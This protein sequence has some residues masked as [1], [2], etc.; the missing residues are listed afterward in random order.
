MATIGGNVSLETF[1]G[2]IQGNINNQIATGRALG[3]FSLVP[4]VIPFQRRSNR[5]RTTQAGLNR[6]KLERQRQEIARK[7]RANKRIAGLADAGGG[8]FN[9]PPA[10]IGKERSTRPATFDEIIS[11][12]G[13]SSCCNDVSCTTYARQKAVDVGPNGVKVLGADPKRLAVTFYG[14]SSQQYLLSP[15]TIVASAVDPMFGFTGPDFVSVKSTDYGT[16][17]AGEWH[18]AVNFGGTLRLTITETMLI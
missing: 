4:P 18:S 16:M 3:H 14:A 9:I 11:R 5:N 7:Q 8:A 17:V 13:D 15:L 12:T 6:R 2:Q 1:L 10:E